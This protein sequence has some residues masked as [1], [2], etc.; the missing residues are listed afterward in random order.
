VI[1]RRRAEPVRVCKQHESGSLDL[2][3][4]D[5]TY[6]CHGLSYELAFVRGVRERGKERRVKEGQGKS[7]QLLAN[8]LCPCLKH[9]SPTTKNTATQRRRG[10][11]PSLVNEL[12]ERRNL[13]EPEI[14][15]IG[16]SEGLLLSFYDLKLNFAFALNF[17]FDAE[18]PRASPG[19]HT[20]PLQTQPLLLGSATDESSSS[21]R[22]RASRPVGKV[23]SCW[24]GLVCWHRRAQD[25][26]STRRG[27]SLRTT[28]VSLLRSD[29]CRSS[30]SRRSQRL[31][32]RSSDA[33]TC[34]SFLVLP[35]PNK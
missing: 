13:M 26:S 11:D 2:S 30:R 10:K 32:R 22:D 17:D 28:L 7:E 29:S 31:C 1:G 23:T 14:I 8:Q 12:E 24:A 9:T 27:P 5:S 25:S 3:Q 20:N 6:P 33:T 19:P 21:K 35:R 15:Y 18:S 16:K 34:E 4:D